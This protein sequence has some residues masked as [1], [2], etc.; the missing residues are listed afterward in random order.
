[1]HHGGY[2][3]S[4][5][6]G[7]LDPVE[8]QSVSPVFV[9]RQD[10]SALLARLLRGADGGTPQGVVVGGEAGVGKTRL[11]EEFL[12]SARAAGATTAV[13]AGVELGADGLPF[14]PVAGLLRALHRQLG[15]ELFEAA[16]ERRGELARLLP[17]WEEAGV[18]A[19][20][21]VDGDAWDRAR[22]FELLTRLLERLARHRT[23][24]LVF[25]DLH[26]ADR[27]TREL[28][29]YYIR[30]VRSARL[31][32]VGSYRTDDLHRRH[33][34]RPFLAQLDRLRTVHR[35]AL[36]PL[37][38]AEVTAQMAGILG[39]PPDAPLAHSV[40]ARTEGNPFFVEE[41]TVGGRPRGALPETLRDL[42]LVR[43]EELD[44]RTQDVLRVVAEGGASVEHALLARVAALPEPELLATLRAAVGARL[45]VATDE[46]D[47]YRFRHALT[48][49][50]VADD[51]L[52]G[53]RARLNRRYAEALADDPTLVAGEELPTRLAS[54]WYHAGDRARALPAVLAA[55]VAAG[56]RFANA[57]QLRL[58]ERALELWDAVEPEARVGLRPA[59]RVWSYPAPEPEEPVGW[60][61]LMAEAVIAAQLAGRGERALALCRRALRE[62]D[63]VRQ[64]L[65]AAWFWT[66]RVGMAERLMRG[67]GSAELARAQELLRGLPP[68]EVHARVLALEAALLAKRGPDPEVIERA[69]RAVSLA[70]LVGAHRTELYA[71]YTLA[72]LQADAGDRQGAVT[73]M[74]A[75][76]ATVLRGGDVALLG[77]CLNNLSAVLIDAGEFAQALEH[78]DVSVELAERYGLVEGHSWL[79]GN[80][81]FA[82][83]AMGRW[84]EAESA[85]DE[86]TRRASHSQSRQISRVL[87]GQLAVLRGDL[88][89]AEAESEAVL[90]EIEGV[91]GGTQFHWELAR[92]R[93]ELAVARGRPLHAR[94]IVRGMADGELFGASLL[95]WMLAFA[96]ATAEAESRGLPGAEQGREAAVEEIRSLTRRLPRNV[97]IRDAMG[98]LVDAQVARARGRDTPRHWA[99]AVDRLLP[100]PLPHHLAEA[101]YGW[102][103][104]LLAAG[105]PDAREQAGEQLRAAWEWVAR[106]GAGPLGERVARLAERAGLDLAVPEASASVPAPAP[107]EPF[108]LTRRE[109]A[110]LELVAAGRS[111]RQIAEQLFISP[112]TVSVHVSRILA[113]LEVT[114]RGEAAAVAHRFRL[115]AAGP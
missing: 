115:A 90:A 108:G 42:L 106:L 91:R 84:P 92:L 83:T 18:A 28:L 37:T 4:V 2:A 35:I 13:G 51:L 78:L 88:A 113:K 60:V 114:S 16:G 71:R 100:L 70:R 53:E 17:E 8:T 43:V 99:E 109:R 102:A 98:T 85:L 82:C 14:A 75:V 80:R 58:L 19:A 29:A 97:P 20:P 54:H 77:R 25:E 39:T 61:D 72:T 56:R 68:S 86:A 15:D 101:R 95:A 33:P 63:E 57:E 10:E 50:A 94:E 36:R 30:S 9:G 103:E 44:E 49:E 12:A 110:V 21:A 81:A 11:L 55:A 46:G 48:R 112:K 41:L 7:I 107:D 105:R 69:E 26:W 87:T 67:D 27:S 89:R 47:G 6:R 32:V 66:Q 31:L 40:F 38:G 96:A 79:W 22:L 104:A 62:L 93:I 64:P 34:L 111:N 65:H 74:R 3:L 52:P 1:M 73:E 5:V 76:L 24:V 59:Q 23:L 45:L